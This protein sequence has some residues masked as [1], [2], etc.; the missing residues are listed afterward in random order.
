[1]NAT[2]QKQGH[3]FLL[4]NNQGSYATPSVVLSP[5]IVISEKEYLS[6]K[7][8]VGYW[9]SMHEKALAKIEKLEN[10]IKHQKGKIRDLKKRVLNAHK[11]KKQK[12]YSI[13]QI[14][15]LIFVNFRKI[16]NF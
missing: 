8:E 4:E 13:K 11:F 1:M 5:Q 2:Y 12:K 9:R 7:C 6:L 14:Q 16:I 10:I 15:F 3:L